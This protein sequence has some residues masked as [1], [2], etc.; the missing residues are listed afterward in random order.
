MPP[1][2]VFKESNIY[3][4]GTS[5]LNVDFRSWTRKVLEP[6]EELASP[7]SPAMRAAV[8]LVAGTTDS[9]SFCGLMRR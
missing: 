4:E 5:W 1:K 8:G 7:G 6:S 9:Q 3:G 2:S